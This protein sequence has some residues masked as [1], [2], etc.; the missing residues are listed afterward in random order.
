MNRRHRPQRLSLLTVLLATVALSAAAFSAAPAGAGGRG[1]EFDGKRV[2]VPASWPVYRL[3]QHP[4]MC[5]RLDRRAVYLGT[6]AAQ[7]RCPATVIGKQRAILVEPE[8]AGAR[9]S[10]LP[11]AATPGASAS[12]G[13]AVFTGLG[14]DAC[15]APSQK[16]M[17]AW[18]ASSP[19]EAIGVYI[20]GSNRGCSQPNLTAS[21]V[22]SQ[23][24]AGWH[25]IP[26]YVG[27]QAPT[28]ACSSC[29]K[30]NSNQATAQ[31]AAAAA[32]A[33]VQAGALGM[34]PG[35][36]IYFDMEAY[37]RTSSATAATLAF[38]ESWTE[39]LHA[40]GYSS[41]VYSSSA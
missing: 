7:Q 19:Y 13:G 26:T 29:A 8:R 22:A 32:D 2:Q 31:G 16:S 37:T 25:L 41:G 5:V 1:V 14:F 23:T 4:G 17:S 28:S 21:W 11:R 39:K 35:S 20:G 38:L 10:A 27:L 18:R 3:A 34:G 15:T 33:V 6:P 24:A 9:G 30:L 36:P 40:L 12:A